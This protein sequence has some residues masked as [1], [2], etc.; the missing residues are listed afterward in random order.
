MQPS[1]AWRGGYVV[2][3]IALL[4]AGSA[5]QARPTMASFP[6]ASVTVNAGV[7]YGVI[8]ATAFGMNTAVWDNHLRDASVPARL[9]TA[10]VTMLRFP[11]G[12]TADN[13]H[14]QTNSMT[15]GSGYVNPNDTFDAFMQLSKATGAQPLITVNYG[16]NVTGTGGG[17]PAEAASW[18]TYANITKGYGVKYWEI[19]NEVYGNGT[20]PNGWETDLHAQKG[21][22]VYAT[23]VVTYA[24]AM[25][26]VDPAI[27]VGL[28]LT[29]PGYW[30]D[31]QS[32]DWNSTVLATAC[33][34]IDFVDVHW[35]PLGTPSGT[36]AGLLSSPAEISAIMATLKGEI[37][38]YCG[39]NAAHIQILDGELNTGT[40][41]KQT[42]GLPNALFLADSTMTWLENG[43]ANAGWW[44]LHNGIDTGGNNSATLYGT[45]AYGDLGI[46][47]SGGSSGA[48]T[49]PAPNVPFP[50]YY[51]LCM[52]ATVGK[53]GDTL[54]A[55][56]SNQ[57]QVDVH[58]VRQARGN[59]TILL[60]NK[61]PVTTYNVPISLSGY[62]PTA[63][64]T[65]FSYG[66]GSTGIS[67]TTMAIAGPSFAVNLPPYSLMTIVLAPA[68]SAPPPHVATATSHTS[69]SSG[70]DHKRFRAHGARS[71]W[72]QCITDHYSDS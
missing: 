20:Y 26:Q 24:R 3:A 34:Q 62:T 6:V 57:G 47:S 29:T 42:V 17:D 4:I 21:P 37:T 52:L 18:V 70:C 41:G 39:G 45:A 27:K 50:A 2:V 64:A 44:D 48:I 40:A 11:G 54:I 55:T 7:S 35:Y 61:D 67:T 5:L 32:P 23:N 46:L 59:V 10:G 1:I 66:I 33:S 30:P 13:Y 12:S 14:W 56:T 60:V 25:K 28:A 36:D 72:R 53:A 38:Q 8:P 63:G 15:P 51:G 68:T 65:V 16:S 58:A 43:A 19:G 22:S 71:A 49:E 69:G 31:G 9:R